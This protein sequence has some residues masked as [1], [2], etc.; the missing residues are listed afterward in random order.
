MGIQKSHYPLVSAIC[1]A[2]F[3]TPFM[4]AGVNTVLPE[5][6]QSL[7]ASAADLGLVGAFY[8]LGLAIFQLASGS[9]GDIFGRRRLFLCGLGIFAISGA[10]LG[11]MGN[12]PLFWALRFIQGIGGAMLSASG[13]ALLASMSSPEERA[14]YLG[15]SSVAVYAGIAAGPPIAG[16]IADVFGWRWLFWGNSLCCVGVLFL[17]VL[18]DKA[19]KADK[20]EWRVA[21]DQTFD[22]QGCVIYGLSMAALTFGAAK[23]SGNSILGFSLLAL[24]ILLLAGFCF[25]E[26]RSPFPMLDLRLLARRR[27]FAFSSLAAFVN[28]SSVFGMIFFFSLYLQAGKGLDVAEAGLILAIGP[29]FQALGTP[30][31]TRLCRAWRLGPLSA[32]GV[33]LCGAGLFVSAFLSLEMS[34]FWLYAAQAT[35]GIGI[36]FFALPNT[37]IILENAGS[38]NIG[39]ASGII[40]AMRTAG[41][42]FSMVVITL[43]M[44]I[45]LGNA[46]VSDANIHEFMRGMRL[47]LILFG[48]LN[49]GAIALV[50]VRNRPRQS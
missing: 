36:S 1:A 46:P 47:D 48:L 10:I 42:L 8:A 18:A 22:W 49:L 2:F 37:A 16:F 19:D 35:L 44:G 45:F 11:A 3:C 28:Y 6:G 5:L 33:A 38:E 17:L 9:L 14:S 30:I 39:Q 12:L 7:D 29:F 50:F 20:Q 21:K 25:Q 23:L 4:I 32:L 26:L 43:S 41:Q 24:A 13:L 40:G 31:A 34:L 15:V 27:T